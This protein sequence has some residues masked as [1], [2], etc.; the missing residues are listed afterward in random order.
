MSSYNADICPSEVGVDDHKEELSILEVPAVPQLEAA[1]DTQESPIPESDV[2][3]A[4]AP[5]LDVP[6]V[7][8]YEVLEDVARELE[9][10]VSLHGV[11]SRKRDN[12]VG[13][14]M[15]RIIH[16]LLTSTTP[17]PVKVNAQQ[18]VR[19]VLTQRDLPEDYKRYM[20]ARLVARSV[21]E[22]LLPSA[23]A[24]LTAR[25]LPRLD[26]LGLTLEN[27]ELPK[28]RSVA[29]DVV[30][31]YQ[32]LVDKY[33]LIWGDGPAEAVEEGEVAAPEEKLEL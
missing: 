10:L 2:Q 19:W 9:R 15:G 17:Q 16:P 20:L 8:V 31:V 25:L 5:S 28:D 30:G 12:A 32:E 26:E 23:C 14:I 7:P 33:E 3:E 1:S 22:A 13:D 21:I 6:G 18:Y 24:M 29:V 27:M 11:K 4:L